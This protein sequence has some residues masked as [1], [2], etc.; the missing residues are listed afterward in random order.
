MGPL[1]TKGPMNQMN[2]QGQSDAL[3]LI[4]RKQLLLY[5]VSGPIQEKHVTQQNFLLLC[6]TLECYFPTM[7]SLFSQ[8]K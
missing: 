7:E 6:Q 5:S 1:D 3:S 2:K 4:H 8:S